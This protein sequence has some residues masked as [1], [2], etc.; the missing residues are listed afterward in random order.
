MRVYFEKPRTSLG[1]RGL[2]IDPKLNGTY[3]IGA[4]LS[5]PA[6]C[7]WRS[8]SWAWGPGPKCWTPSC[9]STSPT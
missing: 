6:G 1:W 9:R 2:I 8:P 7:C 4:G 3:D 5:W